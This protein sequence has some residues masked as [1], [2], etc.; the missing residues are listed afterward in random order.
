MFYRLLSRQKEMCVRFSDIICSAS[1]VVWILRQ[2]SV[3]SSKY[4]VILK[5]VLSSAIKLH[6][7]R[8]K[9]IIFI[10]ERLNTNFLTYEAVYLIVVLFSLQEMLY[11][12]T[13]FPTLKNR[14]DITR[15]I[16]GEIEKYTPKISGEGKIFIYV[17]LTCGHEI[18]KNIHNE[19]KIDIHNQ[20]TEN[21]LK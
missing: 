3:S 1:C 5:V 12:F 7:H 9:Q 6:E 8:D 14:P 19:L 11:T 4:G 18:S 17:T 15:R 13:M 2:I 20:K 10:F 16:L 21:K